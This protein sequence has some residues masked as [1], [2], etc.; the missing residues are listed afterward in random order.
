MTMILQKVENFI[1]LFI[2]LVFQNVGFKLLRNTYIQS[3]W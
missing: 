2:L 1:D 3:W